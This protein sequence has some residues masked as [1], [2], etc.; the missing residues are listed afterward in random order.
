MLASVIITTKNRREELAAA[1]RSALLQS[2]PAEVIVMDDGSSDGTS[3][4]VRAAFPSVRLDRSEKSLGLIAQRNRAARLAQGRHLFSIDDD[5]EF[6]TPHVVEQTLRDFD[7]PRIGAVAIPYVE[8]NKANRPLQTPPDAQGVWLTDAFIGT[9]HALDREI[10]L[11]LG[12]YRE[13]LVHQGEERDFCLRM[14]AAGHVTRLGRADLIRHHE[15]PKRDFSRMDFYG[16]RN[17]ILFAWQNVPAARLPVHLLATT[18]K[19]I[20]SALRVRRLS[21]MLR[22]LVRGYAD[23]LR[24]WNERRPVSAQTYRLHRLLKKSGPMRMEQIEPLLPPL[25]AEC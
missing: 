8:P 22:G 7:H 23:C 13:V 18:A 21:A 15:S 3:E 12:G 24:H 4:M 9:A 2:V 25:P 17:D 20:A 14:L 6:S 10:F 11:A 16:R 1:I 19:G 5:A